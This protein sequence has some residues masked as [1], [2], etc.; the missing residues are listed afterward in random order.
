MNKDFAINFSTRLQK[1]KMDLER[2]LERK[3][4]LDKEIEELR[5]KVNVLEYELKDII[6]ELDITPDEQKALLGNILLKTSVSHTGSIKPTIVEAVYDVLDKEMKAMSLKDIT[7][8]IVARGLI[9]P[10]TKFPESSVSTAIQRAKHFFV[11]EGRGL[12]SLKKHVETQDS[13]QK[14][15]QKTTKNIGSTIDEFALEDDKNE[16]ITPVARSG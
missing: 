2:K 12:W 11:N 6:T 9:N 1:A 8:T 3:D 7:S 10:D 15:V 14:S 4:K 5:N 13:E 16:N